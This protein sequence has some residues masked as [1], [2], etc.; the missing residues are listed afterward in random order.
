MRVVCSGFRNIKEIGSPRKAIQGEILKHNK[1][2][3]TE[4]SM[5]CYS[6]D[7]RE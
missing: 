7:L 2:T 3:T 6:K 1:E 4:A 5:L